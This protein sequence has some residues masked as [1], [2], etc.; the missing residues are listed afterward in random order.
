MKPSSSLHLPLCS[1]LPWRLPFLILSSK[2]LLVKDTIYDHNVDGPLQ[3][4]TDPYCT[5]LHLK[6]ESIE[7]IRKTISSTLSSSTH[8]NVEAS[9]DPSPCE[10]TH[11]N[12]STQ[13]ISH[14]T[15]TKLVYSSKSTTS[16]LVP[17]VYI[18][19]VLSPLLQI[20]NSS[21]ST[22]FV[23]LSYKPGAVKPL[24]KKHNLEPSVINNYRL[25]TRLSF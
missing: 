18:Y 2:L 5:W 13:M 25:V 24:L 17:S 9:C 8:N 23:P 20:I 15:L 22:G 16:L 11:C 1:V 3:N 12:V 14:E 6:K 4:L 19:P 7:G 21:L 10:F